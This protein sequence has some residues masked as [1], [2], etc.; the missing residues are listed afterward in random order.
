MS[1]QKQEKANGSQDRT[2]SNE[3]DWC[4]LNAV[5]HPGVTSTSV[6]SNYLFG[7]KIL[8]SSLIRRWYYYAICHTLFNTARLGPAIC[9][10]LNP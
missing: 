5:Y 10:V 4:C 2:H 1:Y 6:Q 9:N 7:Q 3:K 8:L